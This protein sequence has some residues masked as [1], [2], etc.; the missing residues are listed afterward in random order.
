MADRERPGPG[1]RIDR[2]RPISF[3]FDGARLHGFAGDTLASALLGSG[4]RAWSRSFRHHR[5]RGCFALGAADPT[6]LTVN[7]VPGLRPSQ[8]AL[9]EGLVATSENCWPRLRF[10]VAAIPGRLST[11]LPPAFYY[12]TFGWPSFRLWEPALRSLAALGRRATTIDAPRG[13]QRFVDVARLVVGGGASGRAA[14]LRAAGGAVLWVDDGARRGA[15]TAAIAATA[16]AIYEGNLA[17][18]VERDEA[19][20]RLAWVRADEIVLATGADERPLVFAN[21]D[22]PGVMLA[23]AAEALVRDFGISLG[24]RVVVYAN[25]D[26]ALETARSLLRMGVD[27]VAVVDVRAESTAGV[28]SHAGYEIVRTD[29]RGRVERITLRRRGR[30]LTLGCDALCVGG[31]FSPRLALY[32]QAGGSVAFD[33]R[34]Q[35]FLPSGDAP[36]NVSVVGRAAGDDLTDV[37]PMRVPIDRRAFV[38]LAHDVSTRD[39]AIAVDEGFDAVE[40]AKRWT[41]FGMAPDQGKTSHLN[42]VATLAQLTG[43]S[44][45]DIGVPRA[46]PPYTPVAVP[47]LVGPRRDALVRALRRLPLHDSHVAM[48]GKL[49]DYG[50]WWRPAFYGDAHDEADAI[51]REAR[52]ARRAVSLFD[53]SSLTK[54]WVVGRDAEM[55]LNRVYANDASGLAVGRVRYGLMLN[56]EGIVR[57]DGVLARLGE[58][59]YLVS[60]SSAGGPERYLAMDRLLQTDWRDLDVAIDVATTAW[61]TL[62]I[63]GPRAPAL[64][65][66]L[67]PDLSSIEHMT[68]RETQLGA[69]RLLVMAVSYTGEPSFELAIDAAYGDALLARLLDVGKPLELAPLGLEALDVLRLEKGHFEVGVDTDV[70]TSP[71]DLGWGKAVRRK[72]GDFIGRRSLAL[73]AF[74]DAGRKELVA[75]GAASVLPVGAAIVG[76]DGRIEG[77]VTSSAWSP[78][79][80]RPVAMAL[81]ADGFSRRGAAVAIADGDRTLSA[82]VE[83][84]RAFDPNDTRLKRASG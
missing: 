51:A 74:H 8:V 55:F 27:V 26:A 82:T 61:C 71:M 30:A 36:P 75:L 18:V 65:A 70:D 52:H 1:L 34:R 77:H 28:V 39:L 29:G 49:E 48:R 11:L 58:T 16:V 9:E 19:G 15:G 66:A 33:A 32:A 5:L 24:R 64:L 84:R 21:N 50:G 2:A 57:D 54:I 12:K 59:R 68:V 43:R 7:G 56:D 3:R 20:E 78:T 22:L 37:E 38:D 6:G 25:N 76:D 45:S 10:D 47:T 83:S 67:A 23:S 62:T 44:S 79:L 35:C 60:A 40:L 72:T 4:V 46:R 31:G 80:E 81:L 69:H 73:P 14:A 17:M 13:R 42:A 63:C 53:A 41:T